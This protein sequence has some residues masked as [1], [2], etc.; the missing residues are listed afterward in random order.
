MGK[1]V[2]EKL[3]LPAVYRE[4]GQRSYWLVLFYGRWM[5][6]GLFEWQMR[7]EL[8]SAYKAVCPDILANVQGQLEQ[9]EAETVDDRTFII[10]RP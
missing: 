8:V 3:N 1:R 2:T 10:Q 5:M 7:P 9:R 4:N 6:N